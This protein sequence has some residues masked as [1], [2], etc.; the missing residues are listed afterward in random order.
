M[1]KQVGLFLGKTTA[2]AQVDTSK[3]VVDGDGDDAQ[4]LY[5][6]VDIVSGTPAMIVTV[7][8]FDETSKKGY[9]IL[10]SSAI[11]AG[12]TVMKIGPQLTA[13][14]NVAKDYV[15]HAWYITASGGAAGTYSIGA[16][17]I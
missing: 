14:A 5:V 7:N 13:G 2:A 1:S 6:V 12:T 4:A 11:S 15:P 16:S 10:T 9:P 17:L 8:G 3:T